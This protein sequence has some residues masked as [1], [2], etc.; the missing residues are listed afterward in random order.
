MRGRA[1]L[2]QSLAVVLLVAGVIAGASL[3]GATTPTVHV[4]P[5]VNQL[6][7]IPSGGQLAGVTCTSATHCIAVG[8]D[9]N[10]EP[11]TL[12]GPVSTWGT[13]TARQVSLGSS[14]GGSGG[15]V[16]IACSSA[17]LCVA[18]G[19]DYSQHIVVLRGNPATWGAAQA[20]KVVL[21][22]A[23]GNA[24][25]LASVTCTSSTEC[26]A[27]GYDGHNQPLILRG[28]PAT[29]GAAQ[30]T[31]ITLGSGFGDGGALSSVTCTSSTQCVATGHDAA[32]QPVVVRGNP[33][34][35]GV[36]QATQITLGSGFGDGGFLNAVSCTSS[37]RCVAVGYDNLSQLLTLDGDPATW[38]AAQATAIALVSSEGG[39]GVLSSVSC[40]GSTSCSAVG[41]DAK[42]QLLALT[43]NPATWG[44]P[45]TRAIALGAGSGSG[46]TLASV[47]CTSAASCVAAGSDH[48]DRAL[49]LSGNPTTWNAGRVHEVVLRGAGFGVVEALT[50]LT[51]ESKTLCI[52]VGLDLGDKPFMLRGN[53]AAWGSAHAR[54]LE[55]G[56]A[57]GDGGSLHSMSCMTPISC[58]AVG[59]DRKGQPFMLRGNPAT[60]TG[61]MAKQLTLAA[62]M[63]SG[64]SLA[65]VSCATP[66]LCV[67]VG[68]DNK[69]QPLVL[70]G[71]PATW[72]AGLARQITLGTA[73]GHG[74]RLS[75]IHCTSATACVAVGA[76]TKNEPLEF[77]GNPASWSAANARQLTLGTAFGKGGFLSSVT[78]A[79]TT[80]CIGVGEDDE[81]VPLVV[82]GNPVSWTVADASHVR[83]TTAPGTV[84]GFSSLLRSVDG[85]L[86]G[87]SCKSSASCVA[88]GYDE[89][90]APILASGSPAAVAHGAAGRPH[91]LAS[92]VDGSF[93]AIGCVAGDC[94]VVGVNRSASNGERT[95]FIASI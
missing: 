91:E 90:E 51:C 39:G 49:Y 9:L 75:S 31:A 55:L 8:R 58:V 36:A 18:V 21:G 71:N 1:R 41:Y 54:E 76:S 63:G 79:T 67:A 28:N 88:I 69:G 62:S 11:L 5:I 4:A 15:L 2:P 74:G 44:S 24:G 3:A 72:R 95:A 12:S 53:P 68:S 38:S 7:S 56:A 35:W 14:F 89:Y 16:S 65:S 40:T 33:A 17:T 22:S 32:S 46:G 48:S 23:F 45:Q 34:T 10:S 70:R 42:S 85:S 73:F 93:D 82:T 64:G 86:D 80:S 78:C 52:A 43:G 26:V 30:A 50:S 25:S 37:S 81:S 29:W 66:T 77:H 19:Y 87:V 59:T 60:W 92:F 27:V 13:S 83:I 20:R 94:F 61:P 6:A 57:V 84:E 47:H